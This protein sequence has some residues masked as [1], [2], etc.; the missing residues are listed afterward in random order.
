M[1]QFINT[2][3]SLVT[4]AIDGMLRASGGI[5]VSRLDGYPHI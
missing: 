5:G 3:E 1:A 2:K 4:E